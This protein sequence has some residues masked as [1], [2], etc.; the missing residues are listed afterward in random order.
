VAEMDAKLISQVKADEGQLQSDLSYLADRIGPRLT[1]SRKLDA[2]SDW[3]LEQFKGLGLENAHLEPW[4]IENAWTRGSA[5]GRVMVPTEQMLTL[6]SAG[7][8]PSTNGPVRGQVVGV[9]V[10][11]LDELKKYAGKLKGAI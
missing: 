9:G 5:T 7:W 3:T 2:A 1:G 4:T 10:L 11:K 6:A 8:S